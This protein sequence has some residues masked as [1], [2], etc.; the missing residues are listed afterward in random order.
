MKI[1]LDTNVLVTGLLLFT[2]SSHISAYLYPFQEAGPFYAGSR[3]LAMGNTFVSL[4]DEGEAGFWN[5]AGIVQWQGVKVFA[6]T[7]INDRQDYAFDSKC[8]AYSYRDFGFFWGNKIAL[9]VE[10]EGTADFTYYS[11]AGKIN[12]YLAIGGS[13]KFKRKHPSN[14]YQFFGH[15]PGYDVGLL[16]KP[17]PR[18][19]FGLLIQNENEGKHWINSVVLG[20]T[21]RIPNGIILSLDS[22]IMLEDKI[23]FE[24]HIGFEWQ[25]MDRLALRAG[26]SNGDPTG[27]LGL[28]VSILRIDYA[29]IHKNAHFIS[30][31]VHI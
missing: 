22:S 16:W 7:K 26:M 12:S 28:K 5:P 24:P 23:T 27:G 15:S 18:N 29:W 11:I 3:P 25:I 21:Y 17:D 9:R 13:I 19:S 31:Q 20:Y 14:Y 4:A 10:P 6:S 2:F 1:L 8:V 30:G